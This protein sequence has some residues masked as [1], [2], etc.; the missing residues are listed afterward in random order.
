M[1]CLPN[2][3]LEDF[4]QRRLLRLVHVL[5]LAAFAEDVGV[6]T[7]TRIEVVRTDNFGSRISCELSQKLL[8]VTMEGFCIE[9][10]P[11]GFDALNW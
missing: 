2:I 11:A 1:F 7:G 5:V 10:L 4:H 8:E 6:L 9:I 3:Q